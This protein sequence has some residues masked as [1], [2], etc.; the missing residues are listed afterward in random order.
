VPS[1]IPTATPWDLSQA[2]AGQPRAVTR[3]SGNGGLLQAGGGVPPPSREAAIA[4]NS[5]VA[6]AAGLKVGPAGAMPALLSQAIAPH[7]DEDAGTSS[8]GFFV[9]AGADL[10]GYLVR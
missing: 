5:R 6:V 9:Q 10:P 3:T 2:T 4:R 8:K 7:R 1:G